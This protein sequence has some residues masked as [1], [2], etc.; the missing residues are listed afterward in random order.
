MGPCQSCLQALTGMAEGSQQAGDKYKVEGEDGTMGPKAGPGGGGMMEM[1]IAAMNAMAGG[2]TGAGGGGPS[3]GSMMGL[4]A[5]VG[6]AA[7]IGGAAGGGGGQ[8]FKPP[9]AGNTQEFE[10]KAAQAVVADIRGLSFDDLAQAV[11][12][13]SHAD[14]CLLFAHVLEIKSASWRHHRC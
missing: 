1:G 6:G 4:M 11:C 8:S 7:A 13:W 3:G 14:L 2:P 9:D 5:L 12:T 10:S